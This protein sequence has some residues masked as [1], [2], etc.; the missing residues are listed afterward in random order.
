MAMPP[1]PTAWLTLPRSSRAIWG[2]KARGG[3]G[4]GITN[5]FWTDSDSIRAWK[6]DVD[7]LQAQKQGRTDWYSAYAV[8]IGRIERAYG[9]ALPE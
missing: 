2:T 1:W 7:H 4:F 8:R 3:D 5:S 9:M 6:R